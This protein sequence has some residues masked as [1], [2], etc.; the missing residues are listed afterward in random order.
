MGKGCLGLARTQLVGVDEEGGVNW[1]PRGGGGGWGGGGLGVMT[2]P[3]VNRN[4]T[5][6]SQVHISKTKYHVGCAHQ[7]LPYIFCTSCIGS[8]ACSTKL[9]T[10]PSEVTKVP[11]SASN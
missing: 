11:G 1:G 7:K 10:M 3:G 2:L 6:R 9:C 4:S 8:Q 5:G